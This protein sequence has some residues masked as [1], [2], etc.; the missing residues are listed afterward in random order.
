MENIKNLLDSPK[1]F[2]VQYCSKDIRMLTHQPSSEERRNSLKVVRKAKR[3]YWKS[4]IDSAIPDK[5]LYNVISWHK[6]G[7][8][9]KSPPFKIGDRDVEDIAEKAEALRTEVLERYHDSD[10]LSYN[11]LENRR[12]SES[13]LP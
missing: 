1:V 9:I 10:D 4:I 13:R 5:K 7:P 8:R 6:L 2:V 12:P 3:D 11:P